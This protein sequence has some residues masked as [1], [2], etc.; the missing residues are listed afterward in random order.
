MT[1]ALVG[2]YV[3]LKFWI[4]WYTTRI[5]TPYFVFVFFFMNLLTL[6]IDL[7]CYNLLINLCFCRTI[8]VCFRFSFTLFTVFF[9]SFRFQ[10]VLLLFTCLFSPFYFRSHPTCLFSVTF[11]LYLLN[12]SNFKKKKNVWSNNKHE[13]LFSWC[14]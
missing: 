14:I 8:A 6:N 9:I 1:Y 10:L 7:T 13:V 4:A 2:Y 12:R 5:T 3:W 11:Q